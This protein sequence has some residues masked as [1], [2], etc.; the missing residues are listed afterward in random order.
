[1]DKTTI[2]TLFRV[3]IVLLSILFVQSCSSLRSAP[4]KEVKKVAKK[5]KSNLPPNFENFD[6]KPFPNEAFVIANMISIVQPEMDSDDR[7]EVAIQMSKA[8]Q[9]HKIEPQVVVAIIDT[10][11]NF[12]SD[13]I[14]ST[15]DVSIAQINVEVW[16]KEFTRMKLGLIDKERVKVDQE[17]AITKMAEILEVIKR[18]YSKKDRK[19]YARYHSNTKHYK[20]EY[21]HRLEIRLKMLALAKNLSIK[22][23]QDN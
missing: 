19:W 9:K 14:S 1:M 23:A 10:E 20:K 18:R 17:Y 12:Q 16:N 6:R 21:L 2:R 13:K 3:L 5:H 4:K 11:S 15:G 22:L 8:L 7:D